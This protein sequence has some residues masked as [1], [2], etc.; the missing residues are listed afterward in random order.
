MLRP[1]AS[2]SQAL[3]LLIQGIQ[4]CFNFSKQKKICVPQT[5]LHHIEVLS[6]LRPIAF[7][8][9]FACILKYVTEVYCSRVFYVSLGEICALSIKK[10]EDSV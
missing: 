7:V 4:L 9:L 6:I 5:R 3:N 1:S 8:L 2:L 10:I